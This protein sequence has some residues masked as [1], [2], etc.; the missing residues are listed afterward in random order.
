MTKL[1]TVA[2]PTWNRAKT[3]N[4][5]LSYLLPQIRE[6]STSIDIVISDNGSTDNTNEIIHRWVDEFSDI[7]FTIYTQR[8]NTG[9]FGNFKK[10]K[11]LASGT[12]IWILSDDDFIK[13]NV[14][15]NVMNLLQK[16]HEE[17]AILYL[18]NIN[19]KRNKSNFYTQT[20]QEIFKLF[21]KFNYRLTLASSVIFFNDKGNDNFIYKK[22]NN[23]HLIGFALLIDVFLYRRKAAI[24]RGNLLDCRM[25]IISG[26]NIY[27]A[28]VYNIF[29][30]FEYMRQIGYPGKLISRFKESLILHIWVKRY[31]YF[32]AK[33]KLDAGLESYDLETV[34]KLFWK[35]F[36]NTIGYWVLIFPLTLAPASLIQISF[37]MVEKIRN[38][39]R[40]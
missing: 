24:L 28:F 21:F 18:D 14:V 25:D 4:T 16:E 31:F 22:F 39:L 27:D 40:R 37:P 29:E 2:I 1:L 3:L 17:L 12:F 20:G 6:F 7:E 5:A 8:C 23:S 11:E 34:N 9:F 15:L 32:K 19:P 30:I 36:R 13:E 38:I 33:G 10:C 35:Y 26:Y